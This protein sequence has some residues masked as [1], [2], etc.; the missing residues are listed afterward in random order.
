MRIAGGITLQWEYERCSTEDG[1][2]IRIESCMLEVKSLV[3]FAD[4][5]SNIVTVFCYVLELKFWV[6]RNDLL[7]WAESC[8]AVMIYSKTPKLQ[9]LPAYKAADSTSLQTVRGWGVH[10]KHSDQSAQLTSESL[11]YHGNV[12]CRQYF[13]I[14]C[15][16]HRWVCTYCLCH[17]YHYIAWPVFC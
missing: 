1:R 17:G 5:R 16:L 13:Q 9:W 15:T 10:R 2:W 14:H 6:V 11:T 4:W 8:S 3:V 12:L 7:C